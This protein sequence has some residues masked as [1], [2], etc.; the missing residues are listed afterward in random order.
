MSGKSLSYPYNLSMA[1]SEREPNHDLLGAMEPTQILR[2]RPQADPAMIVVRIQLGPGSFQ[3][4]VA[5]PGSK[6]IIGRSPDADLVVNDPSVSR[7]H[8]RIELSPSGELSIVDQRSTNGTF[9]N[10]LPVDG[11]ARIRPGDRVVVGAVV[12]LIE[13]MSPS[14]L[15]QLRNAAVVLDNVHLDPLTGL[16]T[17]RWIDTELVGFIDR[18]QRVGEPIS[19][20]FMDLDRFKSINDE[21]GHAIGDLVLKATGAVILRTIREHDV[22]IRFGGDEMVL[23]L[24]RCGVDMGV[25]VADRLRHSVR[26]LS[27]PG[28]SPGSV[29]LS[30]GIAEHQGDSASQWLERADAALY[31]AKRAGRDQTGR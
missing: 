20:V 23:F 19:C 4:W 29:R 2:L 26:E 14:E 8:A 30:A 10:Q 22:A 21:H 5:H 6:G 15:S 24:A 12:V 27:V 13:S 9:V 31:R 25:R 1:R 16:T 7:H 18:F 11:R 28:L 17:R 3:A